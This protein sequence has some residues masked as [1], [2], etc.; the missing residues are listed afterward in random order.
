MRIIKDGNDVLDRSECAVINCCDGAK[1][2]FPQDIEAELLSVSARFCVDT[3][4][5]NWATVFFN[6]Y[7]LMLKEPFHETLKV[8]LYYP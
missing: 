3:V 4:A 8:Q 7:N 1:A 5:Q 2:A 6:V